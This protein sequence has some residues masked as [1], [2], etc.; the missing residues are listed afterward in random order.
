MS[1]VA[2]RPPLAAGLPLSVEILW[3]LEPLSLV[4]AWA[5]RP[6]MRNESSGIRPLVPYL[7]RS[8]AVRRLT[9]GGWRESVGLGTTSHAPNKCSRLDCSPSPRVCHNGM[10]AGDPGCG[11]VAQSRRR[12]GTSPHLVFLKSLILSLPCVITLG[13]PFVPQGNGSYRR[14]QRRVNL[15]LAAIVMAEDTLARC[16]N[17]STVDSYRSN[18]ATV[19][20]RSCHN[21]GSAAA[22]RPVCRAR[23]RISPGYGCQRACSSL[24][25]CGSRHREQSE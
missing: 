1:P 13:S 21:P 18:S 6:S 23:S 2:L 16:G 10:F 17:S 9:D 22:R 15:G 5:W 25:C 8:A 24:I 12:L 20:I 11:G 7:L 14:C 19:A 4:Y 3:C